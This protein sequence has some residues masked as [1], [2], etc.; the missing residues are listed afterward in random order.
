M[1]YEADYHRTGRPLAKLAIRAGDIVAL[2]G[3]ANDTFPS[4]GS[5][6]GICRSL[7]HNS[8]DRPS[9]QIG[10]SVSVGEIVCRQVNCK[11]VCVCGFDGLTIVFVLLT[12]FVSIGETATAFVCFD[13]LLKIGAVD[14]VA[15]AGQITRL[16]VAPNLTT[17]ESAN[18]L[19]QDIKGVPTLAVGNLLPMHGERPAFSIAPARF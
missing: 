10:E 13:N 16:I 2:L 14:I 1:R 17:G 11:P 3:W 8:D 9:L 4:L 7:W 5:V 19:C 18:L 12:G 6:K 15:D